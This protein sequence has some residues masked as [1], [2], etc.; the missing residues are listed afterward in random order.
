MANENVS[1]DSIYT[2]LEALK[3]DLESITDRS[4]ELNDASK[5]RDIAS[6]L[7]QQRGSDQATS[8]YTTEHTQDVH[9]IERIRANKATGDNVTDH[10]EI[11]ASKRDRSAYDAD[12]LDERK[13]SAGADNYQLR[14][15]DKDSTHI[16]D[17]REMRMRHLEDLH[18]EKLNSIRMHRNIE[19]K[20]WDNILNSSES[21]K[22]QDRRHVDHTLS[23]NHGTE[24]CC[25]EHKPAPKPHC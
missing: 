3:R 19:L 10:Q 5:D 1:L 21:L 25:D 23:D 2:R 22:N 16:S 8:S 18:E 14:Q 20:M 13:V 17:L 6:N 9:T 15:I 7:E 4:N 11:E 24:D 12:V